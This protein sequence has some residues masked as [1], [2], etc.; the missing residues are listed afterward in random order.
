MA[1]PCEY[2]WQEIQLRLDKPMGRMIGKMITTNTGGWDKFEIKSFPIEKIVGKHD[3]YLNFKGSYGVGS[4]D[5]F[6][7]YNSKGKIKEEILV[8][9]TCKY[10]TLKNRKIEI[11][12]FPNPYTS[13]FTVSLD[14]KEYSEISVS[15]FDINGYEFYKNQFS[16]VSPGTFEIYLNDYDE[17]KKLEAGVYFIKIDL[18]SKNILNSQILKLIKTNE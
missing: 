6:Y 5:W 18:K 4:I 3:I 12:I 2:S 14:N 11:T 17:I 1:V 13:N 9:S 10:P 8:D 7:L 15:V 16:N